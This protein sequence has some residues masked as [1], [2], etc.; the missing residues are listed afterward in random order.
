MVRVTLEDAAVVIEVTGR[1][2]MRISL[3]WAAGRRIEIPLADVAVV[4]ALEQTTR[5]TS[6]VRRVT[7]DYLGY[8]TTRGPYLWMRLRPGAA[9]DQ[10]AITVPNARALSDEITVAR[11]RHSQR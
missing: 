11:A 9:F 5:P 2:A 1:D 6:A 8:V 3:G 10:V 7:R 4:D